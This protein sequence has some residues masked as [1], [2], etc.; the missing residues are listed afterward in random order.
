MRIVFY[1]SGMNFNGKTIE[2]EKSLG[3]SESA[4]YY[5]AREMA[6]LGHQVMV[7]SNI[8]QEQIGNFDKVIYA[9]IGE[10]TKQFPLGKDFMEYAQN[11]PHDVLVM[12]RVPSAFHFTFNSKTNLWWSHDLALKRML[13]GINAQLWN[14]D[15]ILAVSQFHKQQI[16]DTYNIKEDFIDVLPNGIDHSHYNEEINP[17][18]KFKS[19]I[20]VFSS[21]PERGL[22]NLVKPG[23]VMEKLWLKDPSYKLI[24]TTYDNF[25]EDV[26]PVYK[27]LW[28]RCL[29]L[30]NVELYPSQ[31][32]HSLAVIESNSF[33]QVYPTDFEETSCITAMNSQKSG[34][35]FVACK[36]GALE[37]TLQRGGVLWIE[38]LDCEL[39]AEEIHKLAHNY[40]RYLTLHKKCISKS[41][42]Y[43]W[44]YSAKELESTIK[45][46]FA[47][48][49]EN[50]KGLTTHYIKQSDVYAASN[51]AEENDLTDVKDF[52]SENFKQL[53]DSYSEF[54]EGI[55]DYNTNQIKNNHNLGKDDYQLAMPRMQY[56]LQKLS[57]LEKG[58]KV[59]DYGCCVGQHTS[60]WAKKFPHL[61]FIGCDISKIQIDIAN[62]HVK[63]KELNNIKFLRVDSPLEIDEHFDLAICCEVLEHTTDPFSFLNDLEA[64]CCEDALIVISTPSGPCELNRLHVQT[65]RE[66]LHHFEQTDLQ[67]MLAHKKN[68]DMNFVPWETD[69]FGNK[70]GSFLCE[71]RVDF[72]EIGNIDYDRKNKEQAPTQTLST[73]IITKNEVGALGRTLESV[74]TISDEIIVG[75]DCEEG[76]ENKALVYLLQEFNVQYFCIESPLRIGFD[77]ARNLTLE[78][79]QYDWILW[80]DADESLN[81]GHRL[82][83]FLKNNQY[84][85][86][87]IAQHHFSCEPAQLIKTDIP[88]RVFRN[89]GKIKFFGHVHE[90]P[91]E[92]INK[93]AGKSHIIPG[94]EI[95][96]GHYGYDTEATRR[97]R[98]IRNFPLMKI[99]R[100]KYPDRDLGKFLWIRDL[101][102]VNRFELEKNGHNITGDIV[103]RCNEAIGIWREFMKR[104][105]KRLVQDSIQY[106]NECVSILTNNAG[107]LYDLGCKANTMGIGDDL[108]SNL[109]VDRIRFMNKE[110]IRNYTNLLL[111]DKME[112]ISGEYL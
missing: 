111:E 76:N 10:K 99:D 81:W 101:A 9:P 88:C 36:R 66:H 35:P 59:L 102:H 104:K 79:A 27:L 93:G 41:K 50:K 4:G 89:N 8:E 100:E 75:I 25:H 30:P 47:N 110:D 48:L 53:E 21:R 23:G 82:I 68:F 80:I 108:E 74:V 84:D 77:A 1:V 90:H 38:K 11:V 18:E 103:S 106:I 105:K 49:T 55:A 62:A 67:E 87:A 16:K 63:E 12:Q 96:I 54:Y 95:S 72:K 51:V 46:I 112:M 29:E 31:T 43:S 26:S 60:A 83:K 61:E 73:C 15:K 85:S 32:K 86:Y 44:E 56:V 34:T 17:K 22:D 3:G 7:F 109:H 20:L 97:Q 6:S 57:E 71:W 69:R 14:V 52:I 39:F 45:G 70:L 78:R 19:K 37:E 2:D 40:K 28:K 13:P 94:T 58:S 107:I 65:T 24:V 92:E 42:E 91:E 98:F 5:V 33:L 64:V